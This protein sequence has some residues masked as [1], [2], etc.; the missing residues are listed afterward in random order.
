MDS[1][2]HLLSGPL[3]SLTN[4]NLSIMAKLEGKD[5]LFHLLGVDEAETSLR[6][7]SMA[8]SIPLLLFL[9]GFLIL[10]MNL[11]TEAYYS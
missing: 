10:L 4:S 7:D 11:I 8:S 3:Y 9:D 2:I 5:L 1:K 6:S